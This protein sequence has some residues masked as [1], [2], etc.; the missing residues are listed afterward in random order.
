MNPNQ[1][2]RRLTIC[3]AVFSVIAAGLIGL[4]Q[5]SWNL[6]LLVAF[7]SVTAILLT[8][9]LGWFYLHKHL[10]YV[11]MI[12]GAILAI[13]GFLSD[14]NANRLLSVGNLL[15]Y[16]Q[17]P[18]MF[19]KKS[20]RV[21]EQ[22]G[23]FL[24]LELVVAA[25]V[26]DTV[27]F[28]V[29]MLPVLV[30]GSAALMALA[31]FASHLRH[32][33]SVSESTSLWARLLHWMGKEQ[34]STRRSSG[35]ALSAARD[36]ASEPSEEHYGPA[37]WRIGIMPMAIATLLF[38]VAYFYMLPR[39]HSGVFE[40][41]GFAWGGAK[42][43]FSSQV[44][45]QFIGEVLQNDSPAFRMSMVNAKTGEPYRPNQPPYI[46]A[47][48]TERYVE[49]A[50]R[51]FWQPFDRGA[52]RGG[53]YGVQELPSPQELD[54]D[55]PSKRDPVSIT[56]IEKATFGEVVCSL[57]PFA[58][59]EKS[60]FRIGRRD[61]RMV[62]PRPTAQSESPTKRRYTF[63]SY[64]FLYGQDS[65]VLADL[66]DTFEDKQS[67]TMSVDYRTELLRVPT[68]IRAL[69]P[70]LQRILAKSA[71]PL[72][73][74]LS[75]ALYLEDYFANGAEYE[76]SLSLTGPKD[77]GI[78]PIADFILNKKRGHC[79]YFASSLALVLRSIQIPTRLVIGFRPSEYNDIGG[80]FPVL[81]NHAHVW[82]EA[83]FT[84]DEI[85]QSEKLV[86]D[87]VEIPT[88]A[89][90][91][92]W[93]RLDPT[94][95][96]DGS[97]A[98]GSFRVSRMQT[99]D[100]I[101]DLWSEMVM[102]MDKSKQGSLFSLFAESSGGSYARIWLQIQN[103][104]SRMQ[105]SRFIGGLL[106][107]EKWFSWRV[108]VGIFFLGGILIL[109]NR[110]SPWLFPRWL[111]NVF[112]RKSNSRSA[113]SRVDFY[114][115]AVKLLQKLGLRR[116][117]SQ[118]QREYL[119]SAR[120]QLQSIGIEVNDRDLSDAFYEKR[121]GGIETITDEQQVRIANALL[122]IEAALLDGGR[123]KLKPAYRA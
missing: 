68:E 1:N 39:L 103:I 69:E 29:L 80:Y 66:S 21:Y 8:D 119:A 25:L 46:R 120:E 102:N 116:Q 64:G 3:F 111:P 121:F 67:G 38:S 76:Y 40:R 22:W 92:V 37:R 65:P 81:Q 2:F 78:D 84:I 53:Q 100:A 14:T 13:W 112:R 12:G 89:T 32:S 71:D 19:Q 94:P 70:E 50:G 43:G 30:L 77:R 62:D 74:K 55:I 59:I 56:V 123:R 31:I 108:A 109:L 88:W 97:N 122:Q 86:R 5:E 35:V 20:K 85:N 87:S 28:G 48:V 106:S 17:L 114:E 61:W 41:D 47:T 26:N 49:G 107:P 27:L 9:I 99:L 60:P 44:S 83:Y 96:V 75:Q 10:V 4:G 101:E 58:Q 98:G 91:G 54:T 63:Q 36:I 23:V 42:I 16:V 73:S 105:S 33:E 52:F 115:K 118:T 57:P 93:L 11:G 51:G 72:R 82:V 6:P 117:S 90:K 34:L 79:Q 110:F 15:V 18:L 95:P 24:L 113:A 7:V 104:L 45:L